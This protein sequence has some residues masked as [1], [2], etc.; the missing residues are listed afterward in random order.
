MKY[1]TI[2]WDWNGTLLNDVGAAMASVNDMLVSRGMKT[3]DIVRYKECISVP[4]IGF[5]EKVFD[6]EKEDYNEILRQ[7]NEGYLR[8]LGECGLSDG[9]REALEY[10]RNENCIQIIVSSSNNAQLT[11]NVEKYGIAEYFDA[12]LGAEN[13]LAESKIGRA[14]KFLKEHGKGR[15]LVI[16]DLEHDAEMA[17][18]LGAD[19]VLLTTGH[20]KPERLADSGAE[21]IDTLLRLP[22]LFE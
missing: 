6:L 5:Y 9:V 3:I 19:C 13:Y 7:Y 11:E 22:S 14:E 18:A 15:V 10:F 12:V 1:G 20:E 8:H 4:I 16:G 21:V 17:E 2:I